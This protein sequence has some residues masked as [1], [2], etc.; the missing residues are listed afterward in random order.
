MS[1]AES[2]LATTD[3]TSGTS[4]S[5]ARVT[6]L[7]PKP[8]DVRYYSFDIW[9][10]AACL[11]LAAYHST[12]YA[13]Y[14][15]QMHD[16]STW[17]VASWAVRLIGWLWVGVP[18]FF[19]IS[20]YCIAAST[21]SLRRKPHSLRSYVVRRVRRIYPPLWIMLGLA[22]L[23]TMTI[24]A[25]EAVA[26]N[27]QQIPQ[28]SEFSL[29]SWI[30]NLTA[31][32]S[33][34]HRLT[35]QENSTYLM[36]NTWTLCYEEQF[37]L[38]TGLLLAISGARFFRLAAVVTVLTLV[39]RHGFRAAGIEVHGFFFDGH[40]LMFAAGILVYTTLNYGDRRNRWMTCGVLGLFAVYA[41]V[42][43]RLQTE[44]VQ[45]HLDEYIFISSL[46]G[47]ALIVFRNLDKPIASLTC[48]KPLAACGRMS[49]SI[50]L[51][52]YLLV[53]VVSSLFAAAGFHADAHV[54]SLV[55]PCCLLLSIPPAWVFNRTVERRFMNSRPKQTTAPNSGTE[56]PPQ[57][58]VT[59]AP[60]TP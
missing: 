36:P 13:E 17:S 56:T 53:V 58:R 43:R 35:G 8:A 24:G 49:Y 30:G 41:F 14:A 52:H 10:G 42:D 44:H 1:S 12:F 33:W 48:L 15:W 4:T 39:C 23:F 50:Y 25:I 40:W 22:V 29:A 26:T 21:D 20:G 54:A 2:P 6:T 28:L 60:Q 45:R 46:F 34:L 27:C 55:V 5:A 3:T 32:E 11:M 51:T 18:M 37:Y 57:P 31:S 59:L 47:I 38:V 19:V 7:P 9:R 16:R